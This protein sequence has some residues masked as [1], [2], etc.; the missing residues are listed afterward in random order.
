MKQKIYNLSLYI[1]EK[2]H[3]LKWMTALIVLILF[4]K[5]LLLNSYI[6]RDALIYIK[7]AYI[8]S[9][10]NFIDGYS[11]YNWPF[12]SFLISLISKFTDI[13]IQTSAHLMNII[14][15][16]LTIYFYLKLL[17]FITNEKKII[18]IGGLIVL[19]FI[20][21]IDKY[22]LM[23]IRDHGFWFFSIVGVYFFL[24]S[25][26]NDSYYINSLWK[27]S[28]ILSCMFRV[29]ALFFLISVSIYKFCTVSDKSISKFIKYFDYWLIFIFALSFYYVL[30]PET[31][32]DL[33][34]TT[35]LS[36][37][38]LKF[39]KYIPLSSN[40]YF[41]SE[42]IKD[43]NFLI[44][45]SIIIGISIYKWV[46]GL[47]IFLTITFLFPLINKYK[48]I[49]NQ[50]QNNF[51]KELIFLLVLSFLPVI[52]NLSSH[53]VL[54]SRYLV[55]HWFIVL[56]FISRNF[57]YLEKYLR[58]L[59]SKFILYLIYLIIFIKIVSLFYIKSEDIHLNL[60][61]FILKNN[62][63]N[64]EFIVINDERLDYLIDHDRF[65][66]NFHNMNDN[67]K[68]VYDHEWIILSKSDF[69][70][71][72]QISNIYR[73]HQKYK[74]KSSFIYVLKK[75]ELNS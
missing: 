59:N 47:G 57:Y 68:S 49:V 67:Y 3:E 45:V 69:E 41:L 16:S 1:F 31:F 11:I 28:F 54:T 18:F 37:L 25:K 32:F 61:E 14:F 21:I 26:L 30:F 58:S 73:L 4:F 15:F 34:N 62:I 5:I 48:K 53:Y 43:H 56:L 22:A 2:L 17:L 75:R 13:K 50:F 20:S 12:Y 7:Q 42:L 29:E 36:D 72:S 71:N 55:F 74:Y 63:K 51:H 24:K 6:N 65:L 70:S 23:I 8:F 19:I 33:Y 10:S 40:S 52:Y 44:L 64:N 60:K 38:N 27:L 9:N 66:T 35:K 46:N 39:I